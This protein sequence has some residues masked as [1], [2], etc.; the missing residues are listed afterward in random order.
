MQT[1]RLATAGCVPEHPISVADSNKSAY[2]PGAFQPMKRM[3]PPQVRKPPTPRS[4]NRTDCEDTTLG[5]SSNNVF[6]GPR[7]RRPSTNRTTLQLSRRGGT[8]PRQSA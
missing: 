6:R 1:R 7:D 5:D 8:P 3:Q 2:C 4:L